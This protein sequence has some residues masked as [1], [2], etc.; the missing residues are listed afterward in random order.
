MLAGRELGV[1]LL[2][3]MRIGKKRSD[4]SKI[5]IG[6]SVTLQL[7]NANVRFESVFPLP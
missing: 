2:V 7:Y 6:I 4:L 1:P 3:L 5:A